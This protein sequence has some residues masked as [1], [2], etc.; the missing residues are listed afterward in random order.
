MLRSILTHGRVDLRPLALRVLLAS[1]CASLGPHV[2][3]ADAGDAEQTLLVW[4]GDQAHHAPDFVAVVD[5]DAES[6]TYGTVLRT[7]PLPS[8]LGPGAIGNEPH[9]V[10]L[11]ADSRTMALG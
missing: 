6:P 5:F 8:S 9:H 1:L 3:R 10:G 11:S 4:A 2:I 7:V